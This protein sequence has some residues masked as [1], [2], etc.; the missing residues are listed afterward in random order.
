MSYRRRD[1]RIYFG[2]NLIHDG[3]GRLAVGMPVEVLE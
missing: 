1:N 3:T 2:Q